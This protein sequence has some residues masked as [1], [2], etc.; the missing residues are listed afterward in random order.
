LVGIGQPLDASAVVDEQRLLKL[1]AGRREEAPG[2]AEG[3]L[4][5]PLER[6]E[7]GD[8]PALVEDPAGRRL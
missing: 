8:L 5:D 7:F 2:L 3:S 6:F 1:V 4:P